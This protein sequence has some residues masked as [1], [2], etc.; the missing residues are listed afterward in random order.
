MAIEGSASAEIAAP[1][2]EVFA[3]AADVEGS[4][5]WQP[6]IKVAECLERNDDGH[7]VLVRTET[8]A[9]VRRLGSTLRFGYDDPCRDQLGAGERGPEV[10]QGELGVRGPRQ[11]PHPGDVLD[12]GRPRPDA[13]HG[14]S[15]PARR[16]SPRAAGREH[17]RQAQGLRRGLSRLEPACRAARPRL[18]S[19]G[20]RTEEA[21]MAD[22]GLF[23]GWG[24]VVRGREQR[25]LEV[26]N[27]SV[28]YWGGLQ[29][30]GKIEDFEVVLLNPH[31]GDLAGFALLRGSAEQMD[32]LRN[33]E[34]VST[35][36]HARRPDRREPRDRRR[37]PRGGD[38]QRDGHVPGGDRGARLAPGL[39]RRARRAPQGRH[40]RPRS[41]CRRG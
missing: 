32:A 5:R 25:A 40:G 41:P 13:R 6:E 27:E 26:F 8:D 1:I 12:G 21:P 7:Q 31:G 2:E 29:G 20:K 36:E 38:R 28:R 19:D 15:R 16:R 39:R 18:G 22:A 34:R 3:V 35:S 17:A 9:K 24:Q 11:R 14:H 30:D 10:G 23:I 4:P 33:D 37:A